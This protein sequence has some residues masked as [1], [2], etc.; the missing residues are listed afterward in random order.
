[1]SN[2][3]AQRLRSASALESQ[4]D[5]Q[6]AEEILRALLDERPNSDGGLFALERV[7]RHQGEI[8]RILGSIDSFLEEEPESSGVRFLKLRI[9]T[10]VDS[11]QAV[12]REAEVWLD[13]EPTGE[14]AYREIGRAYEHAFGAVEALGLLRRG[15]AMLPPNSLAIE[16]GDLLAATDDFLGAADEWAVAVG[17]DGAQISTITRRVQGLTEQSEEVARRIVNR[18]VTSDIPAR[19]RAA[20]RAAVDLSLHQVALNVVRKVADELEGRERATFL[21]DAA[22]RARD[23]GMNEVASWAY[24]ELGAGASSLAERR[25]FDQSIVDVTLAAGDT[26]TALEAQRRVAESFSV[27]SVDRRRA[28]AQVIQ[29]ESAHSGPDDLRTM[30]DDFRRDFPSAPELDDLAAT[31]SGALQVRGDALGASAVL[32]G[33]QGPKSS[34]ERG[35]LLL[36]KGDLDGG[37]SALLL[38]LTGLPAAEATS[39]IQLAGLLGRLSPPAALVLARAGVK[40]HHGQYL[41]AARDLSS[42]AAD[43]DL[44]EAPTVLAEA[45]RIALEGG[46][47]ELAAD[48]HSFLIEEYPDAPEMAEAALALARHR[49]KRPRGIEE[50]IRLLE[51]LITNRPNAAVVPDAR[52]ELQRLR[53]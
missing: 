23:T 45:A 4:G 32:D 36:A 24:D 10:E 6:G 17:D 44:E 12:R 9:L 13:A 3:D 46:E 28:M 53:G 47:Y 7:L 25:Q 11:L 31:I 5:Y 16:I 40:A 48:I 42:A 26:L 14:V 33:V 39:V 27:G 18:L 15:R 29:L 21:A 30:L 1:M 37:R 50:A 2:T 49:A 38:A 52:V 22:R 34:L 51:E 19:R 20:V 43:L 8:I 41:A 35:Y